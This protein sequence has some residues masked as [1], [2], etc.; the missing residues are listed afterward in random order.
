LTTGRI[1]AVHGRFNF[2]QLTAESRYT[3]QR[4]APFPLR[5]APFHGDVNPHLI[6]GSLGGRTRVLNTNGTSTETV[7]HIDHRR[8]SLYFIYPYIIYPSRLKIA[9]FHGRIWTPSNARFLEPIGAQTT[10]SIA[11]VSAVSCTAHRSVSLYVTCC[12][13]KSEHMTSRVFAETTHVV[14]APHGF[15][16]VAITPPRRSYTFQVSSKSLQGFLRHRQKSKFGHF[17]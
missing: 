7:L 5:I 13:K 4:A 12:T 16:S 1:A 9:P 6:L 15:A 3:L 2:A 8:M 11:I 14:A 10:N 17:H